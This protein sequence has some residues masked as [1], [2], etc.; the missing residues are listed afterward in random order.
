MSS[1]RLS[2][3]PSLAS[4]RR[5][6]GV[7]GGPPEKGPAVRGAGK[8]VPRLAALL[9]D[10][11][12]GSAHARDF[13][14]SEASDLTLLDLAEREGFIL[15]SKDSD[16]FDPALLRGRAARVVSL[17]PHAPLTV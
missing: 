3:N 12:P 7:D 4:V 6:V 17:P 2:G 5:Q 9:S 8:P 15:V 11:H 13:G 16:F 14:L 1:G 10:A